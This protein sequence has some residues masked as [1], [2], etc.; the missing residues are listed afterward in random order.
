MAR[1][2]PQPDA[3]GRNEH[4]GRRLFDEPM[5]T[6]AKDQKPFN[7]LLVNHFLE[8]RD[9]Q[10]S[11]DRLGKSSVDRSVVRYLMPLAESAGSAF[12]SP[13]RFDGWT[14]LPA[15][16]VQETQQSPLQVVASPETNNPYH[17]HILTESF[18]TAVEQDKMRRHLVALYLRE[19]F[20]KHG[21]IHQAAEVTETTEDQPNWVS[22]FKHSVL[23]LFG[24]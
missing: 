18:L 10:V 24:R 15:H 1:W 8:T 16:R 19:L 6:G 12:L 17:A 11:V 22:K 13:K 5:L 9:E 3:V 7:G 23:R 4:I 21:T 20:T 14:V 2:I